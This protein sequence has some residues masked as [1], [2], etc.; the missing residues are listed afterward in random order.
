MDPNFYLSRS[1]P[2]SD[3]ARIASQQGTSCDLSFPLGYFCEL[4]HL[5]Y[6]ITVCNLNPSSNICDRGAESDQV[7]H[8][9]EAACS[10]DPICWG[11]NLQ[12]NR[13]AVKV[14]PILCYARAFDAGYISLK[15]LLDLLVEPFL[16]L[17][18][19]LNA[20][21]WQPV[22]KSSPKISEMRKF[23]LMRWRT[24]L[25]IALIGY[26]EDDHGIRSYQQQI[27]AEKRAEMID[28]MLESGHLQV[29]LCMQP[30][31]YCNRGQNSGESHRC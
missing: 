28:L 13:E 31:M 18:V 24:A 2:A 29:T 23:Y 9:V 5:S 11:E 8:L 27:G 26:T 19:K 4:T 16:A 25:S 21:P 30:G 17:A 15:R 3:I 7:L 12:L 1:I 6:Q 22:S 10:D 14:G 20:A